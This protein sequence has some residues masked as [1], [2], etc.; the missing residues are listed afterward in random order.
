MTKNN[1]RFI[2]R[3]EIYKK[4]LKKA[5]EKQD[6]G[7]NNSKKNIFNFY[8]PLEKYFNHVNIESINIFKIRTYKIFKQ[9]S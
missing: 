7:Q 5:K 6:T 4:S 1:Q 9:M 8:P 2:T 3:N